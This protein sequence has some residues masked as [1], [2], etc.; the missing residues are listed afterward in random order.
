VKPKISNKTLGFIGVA[1]ATLTTVYGFKNRKE[2]RE[3]T[4]D[5]KEKGALRLH[6]RI[7]MPIYRYLQKKNNIPF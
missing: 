4:E 3:K 1:L 2:I 6:N 7:G 5:V